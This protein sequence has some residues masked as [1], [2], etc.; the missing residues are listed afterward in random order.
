MKVLAAA[1]PLPQRSFFTHRIVDPI[2][3]PIRQTESKML[4]ILRQKVGAGSS[5][6]MI[7]GQKILPAT[8]AMRGFAASAKEVEDQVNRFFFGWFG[9]G[10]SG[11]L[12]SRRKLGGAATGSRISLLS[13]QLDQV[14]ADLI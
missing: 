5:S 6:A 8:S 13:L 4:G 14:L 9:S 2:P 7:L 10:D 12:P 3:A 1:A 11:G